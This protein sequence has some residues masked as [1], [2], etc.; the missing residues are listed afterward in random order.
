[1]VL[2]A[3]MLGE[4]QTSSIEF[5][6]LCHRTLADKCHNLLLSPITSILIP[7][8]SL[9]L[10][11]CETESN[12]EKEKLKHKRSKI[13]NGTLGMVS[14]EWFFYHVIAETCILKFCGD[15]VEEYPISSLNSTLVKQPSDHYLASQIIAT[16]ENSFIC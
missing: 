14:Q 5:L 16:E 2:V 13:C 3:Q 4:K 1:M 9:E 7:Q 12:S 15:S 8:K 11:I 6:P 10:G